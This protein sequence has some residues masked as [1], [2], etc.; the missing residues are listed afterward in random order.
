MKN[1]LKRTVLLLLTSAS[2]LLTSCLKDEPLIN[3][4]DAI[5][6]IELPYKSH[7]LLKQKI[8]QGTEVE[9]DF[10]VNYTINDVDKMTE[11]IPVKLAVDESLVDTWN[12]ANTSKYELLPAGTYTLPTDATLTKGNRIWNGQVVINT[13]SLEAGGKYMLP[14]V[15]DNV[16]DKYVISG[17][18]GHLYIRLDL[19]T[20]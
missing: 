14:I 18:F 15:I 1:I 3:W 4:D 20:E 7:Y 11:D 17:N 8:E 12:S 13:E 2:L 6:V 16:P 9:Y 10:M 5:Y 19:D